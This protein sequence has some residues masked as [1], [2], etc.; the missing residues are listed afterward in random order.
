MAFRL[1]GDALRHVLKNCS[2]VGATV[3]VNRA[4]RDKTTQAVVGFLGEV[5]AC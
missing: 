3:E 4:A 2:A 5:F 1:Q